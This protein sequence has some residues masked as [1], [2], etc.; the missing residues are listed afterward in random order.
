MKILH[1]LHELKFSG[2]EIM[3]VD[4]AP[5]FQ[6]LGCKLS[7]VNTAPNLGEYSSY[8]EKAG[9][10]VFHWPYPKSYIQRW[11][12]YRKV[13]SFLKQE[14]YDAVHIHSSA[15][16]WGI[17]YCAW[18]AGCK[19]VYTFHSIFHSHWYSYLYHRWLRWSAKH[20]FGCT[21][22]TISDSVYNNEKKY[23]HNNT[24]KI[25]NWYG[26]NR[27]YPALK[28]EKESVREELDIPDSSLVLIS[29]GG[30]S[31]IKRHTDIIKALPDILKVYP[32]T[33]YLHLGQGISLEEEKRLAQELNI[34]K[35]IRF[36]GNQAGVRKYLIASDIYLMTSKLEGIS[37]TTIEAMSCN[38]PAI[39]YNVI[40]LRDFNKSKEC[41]VLIE[42]DYHLLAKNVIDLYQNPNKQQQLIKN[43]KE[44]VDST[45]YMETN[46]TKIFELYK[47]KCNP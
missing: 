18:Q 26:S 32:N 28:G 12:Y 22:Q 47:R 35:N 13:I 10:K 46:A 42:E 3:Y 31:P 5:I 8:F 17:S 44:F 24:I 16:K 20:L 9:Y 6:K 15:L 21:F 36:C 43:A 34:D 41:S 4:A 11:K 2:A 37:L 39:L 7:V 27:F 45:F 33:I 29:V 40:G 30:C 14:H 25:Y 19:P 1:I 38:I 23:Y